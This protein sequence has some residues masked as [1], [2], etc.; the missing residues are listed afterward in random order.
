MNPKTRLSCAEALNH[1]FF[2]N[3]P[4]ACRKSEITKF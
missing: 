2:S 3:S 4:Q 1:A